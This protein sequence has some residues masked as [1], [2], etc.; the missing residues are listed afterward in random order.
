MRFHRPFSLNALLVLG[1]VPIILITCGSGL[2]PAAEEH[3][4]LVRF[5]IQTPADQAFMDQNHLRFVIEGG[6]RGEYYDVVVRADEVQ[7]LLQAGTRVE[8]LHENLESFYASRLSGRETWGLYHTFSEAIAWMDS[9][10]LEYPQVVS[11]RW[12]IGQG[13]EGNDLWCIRVSDNPEIDEPDEPE[14]LFDGLHHANE[15]MGLEVTLMLAEY[16]AQAYVAGDPEIMTLLNTREIYLVPIVNPD[17][18]IY[19]EQTYPGGGATW[20]KNRRDNGDGSWGVDLNR[21]YS[22]EWGCDWGSS[23]IPSDPTYR[24]PA[25]ESEPETQ[26]ICAFI[27]SREFVV[28]QSY[29]SS[30]NITLY[31][32]GYT[33]DDTPDAD[34]F[35]E[36]AV[37][38]TLYNGYE[39][40]QI[41]DPGVIYPVCGG[42]VDW[43][44]GAQDRHDKIFGFSN[45]LGTSQWPPESQRQ[46]IFED[47][48]WPALY[49]IQMAGNLRGVSWTHA[50]LPYTAEGSAPYSVMAVAQ[51]FNDTPIDEST[52]TLNYRADGG[53]FAQAAML[54]TGAPGEYAAEIPVQ[55]EG[56][57]VEYYLAASDIEGRL[58]TSPRTAPDALHYFEVGTEFTHVMEADRGWSVGDAGDNATSGIWARVDPVGTSAQPEDDHSADGTHCWITGQH[59]AGQT[60]GYNDVDNGKTTLL[61]PVYD[62]TGAESVSF[63]YWLWYSNDQG[64]NPGTDYW[65]VLLSNDGGQTWLPLEHTAISTNAW[66]N[67][68]YDL[69]DYYPVPEQVQLKFVAADESPGSLVEAGVDDFLILGAFGPASLDDTPLELHVSLAQNAPNPFNPRTTIRYFLP[70]EDRVKLSILDVKGRLIKVLVSAMVPA[71]EH[72]VT[73]NGQDALGRRVASGVYFARLSTASGE[74]LSCRMVLMK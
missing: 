35:Y 34:I 29:H 7:E 16:L 19:N 45:E 32:W 71:G 17:G 8:V 25:A 31:P 52:V 42:S 40:G 53:D 38:M 26:A 27:D 5:W 12:S 23:G 55:A 46:L 1:F 61:S 21:N 48:I 14:I 63:N 51:G 6:R 15:I 11:A 72:G 30:G 18:L 37:A 36:M 56:A 22:F 62:M 74:N 65:D 13:H 66:V 47:N 49:L 41:G 33:S 58:G 59:L 9:L 28:R 2:A 64:N 70:H 69:V 3:H 10:N 4:A 73:W 60:P 20:R 43:D 67:L 57:V 68:T 50:P 54:P 24:G 44:Y 39:F